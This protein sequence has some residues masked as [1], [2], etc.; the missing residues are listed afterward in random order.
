VGNYLIVIGALMPDRADYL[1]T[2][3]KIYSK[4]T[5]NEQE[6]LIR[7]ILKGIPT[8]PDDSSLTDK[9]FASVYAKKVSSQLS[10][11]THPSSSTSVPISSASVGLY[12]IPVLDW[13][14][15][16][17]NISTADLMLTM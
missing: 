2:F 12:T 17:A 10:T 8:V 3:S 7:I 1:P 16:Y 6:W 13:A 11:R 9:T 14:R 15:P 4:M 5:P